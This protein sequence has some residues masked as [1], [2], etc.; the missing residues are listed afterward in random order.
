MSY[1]LLKSLHI[2]GVVLLLG[3][4]IV[5]AWWKGMANRSG[6]ARIIAFAQRQVTL[7]DWLFTLPG[8]ALIVASGDY[9]AYALI[10]NSWDIGWLTWGRLLFITSGL[11]W[12]CALVP[13]QIRQARMA[14]TFANDDRIP[15]RYWRLNRWWYGLGIVAVLL[16]LANL[17]WM[18]FKPA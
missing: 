1:A 7:T 5:T 14:R 12:L 17:Y 16:P 13:I 4:V 15:E 10:G 2:L 3:N 11:I 8:A 6:D 9:I 18:V